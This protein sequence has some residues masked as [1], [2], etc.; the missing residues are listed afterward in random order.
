MRWSRNQDDA[1]E[2]HATD[3]RLLGYCWKN[4]SGW[5]PVGWRE[6]EFGRTADHL[7]SAVTLCPPVE[8]KKEAM[9]RVEQWV[10]AGATGSAGT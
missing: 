3:G 8:S 7:I 9:C 1:L 5:H 6:P 10:A 4:G 2:L